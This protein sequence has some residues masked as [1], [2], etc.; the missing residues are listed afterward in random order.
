R[1]ASAISAA[2]ATFPALLAAT[3]R[4]DVLHIASHTE[5]QAGAGDAA[6]VFAGGTGGRGQRVSWNE[7][8]AIRLPPSTVVCLAGCETLCRP[9]LPQARA[10]SLGGGFLAAGASDVIGTLAPIEDVDA[11]SLFGDVHRHLAAGASPA[12]AVRSVQLAALEAESAG[13]RRLAWRALALLTRR[14]PQE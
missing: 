2:R 3:A 4:A 14:L 12:E 8:A 6:L 11:R 5:R 9:L 1:E 13:R 10:L 7:I